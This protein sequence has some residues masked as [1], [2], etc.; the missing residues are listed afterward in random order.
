M[1][2][3]TLSAQTVH[4]ELVGA[5][6]A[7]PIAYALVLLVDSS[8]H[9]RARTLSDPAGQ[10]VLLAPSPGTY[11]IRILRIGFKSFESPAMLLEGSERRYRAA[12]P[13]VVMELPA[14]TVEAEKRCRTRPGEGEPV[15]Q[16]LEQAQTVLRVT[17]MAVERRL[18]RFRSALL[19]RSLDADLRQ[20]AEHGDTS[21][22]FSAWPFSSL[23]PDTLVQNGFVQEGPTGPTYYSPDAAVFFSDAFLDTHCFSV[24]GH[25]SDSTLVGLRFEPVRKRKLP[26]IH[27][28]LWL[29]RAS[30]ELRRLEYGYTGL[31][32]W[33]PVQ[34]IGGW[35]D[36]RRLPN[37]APLIVAWQIRAPIP[38]QAG[39]R[40]KLYGFKEREGRVINV[41]T[42]DG[43][44]VTLPSEKP[45]SPAP[46]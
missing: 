3:A 44:P 45:W 22:G 17:E 33:V 40:R 23:S 4:G 36:F 46:R 6:T 28:V 37:G 15:A 1:G 35:I 31:E 21:N 12:L 34:L 8:G 11:R 13:D 43:H 26:D 16:L 42:A 24:E 18:F 19:D 32:G 30:S 7:Q 14:V 5:A 27:G 25:R 39:Q 29:D 9:E 20:T 10:F 38:L 2:V 41:F